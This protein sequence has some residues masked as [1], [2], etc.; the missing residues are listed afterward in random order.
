MYVNYKKKTS[1]K[2]EEVSARLASDARWVE[3]A[4][5]ILYER[6]IADEQQALTTFH[7]NEIGYQQADAKMF[8]RFSVVI[9]ARAAQG[10]P[11]GQRLTVDDLKAGPWRMWARPKVPIR[12]ICKYRKQI[13][14][15][16][17]KYALH[18]GL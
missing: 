9:A 14:D 18:G 11:E 15:H 12:T 7:L 4:I 16:I 13:L 5:Q 1:W 2:E 8:S 6:Q 17:E 10:I 3:K